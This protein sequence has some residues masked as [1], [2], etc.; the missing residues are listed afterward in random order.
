MKHDETL[1]RKKQ[2][3]KIVEVL[4][5]EYPDALGTALKH[6]DPLELL[7][8]T[9][10]SAQCTDVRV[11]QV[12]KELFKKYR[13]VDDFANAP[14]EEL[15]R[16]VKPTGFY[17]N[18]ASN[19]KKTSQMLVERFNSEVPG[20]MGDLIKLPGVGRKTANV[21][22]SNAFG[23]VEGVVVD[24]H[25]MRISQRLALTDNRDQDKIERDLMGLLPR[26]KWPLISD[27]LM[28]H[29]RNI[30]KARKPLCEGCV[31]ETLCPSSRLK[32]TDGDG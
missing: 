21:I 22:L 23:V 6:R 17:R 8:A 26:E 24:T 27:L 12:A 30:C 10:L 9:I 20:S 13:S 16:D 2:T 28:A 19:I 1:E 32:Q 14:L 11:N 25:V 7:V 5:A 3:K 29:G 18:K 31:V 15:E 4:S